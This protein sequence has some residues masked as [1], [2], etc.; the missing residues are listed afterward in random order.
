MRRVEASAQRRVPS[1][2]LTISQSHHQLASVVTMSYFD[3]VTR[4]PTP[5]LTRVREANR[6]YRRRMC[7]HDPNASTEQ[8]VLRLRRALRQLEADLSTAERDAQAT[9]DA[10]AKREQDM[11]RTAA[12]LAQEREEIRQLERLLEAAYTQIQ[13]H[14]IEEP[15]SFPITRKA[16]AL[17][18]SLPEEFDFDAAH[19]AY[20]ELEE[21]AVAK[22]LQQLVQNGVLTQ[23]GLTFVKTGRKPYF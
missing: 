10:L 9:R 6:S 23:E 22:L 7:R 19:G 18:E 21:E 2:P 3:R 8:E 4:P 16:V 13:E 5:P 1:N 20:L 12:E 15:A 14:G 17:A 11:E